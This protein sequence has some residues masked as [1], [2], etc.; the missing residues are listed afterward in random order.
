M[1]Y[2]AVYLYADVEHADYN[3]LTGMVHAWVVQK[4]FKRYIFRVFMMSLRFVSGALLQ[5]NDM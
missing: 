4:L 5:L 2:N 3:K 1:Q